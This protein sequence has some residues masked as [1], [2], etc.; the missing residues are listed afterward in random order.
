MQRKN[1]M[2]YIKKFSPL[3]QICAFSVGLN[4]VPQSLSAPQW[5]GPIDED[6]KAYIDFN[7]LKADGAI[8]WVT[9]S[10][11]Q[12]DGSRM[13]I[14][15]GIDCKKWMYSFRSSSGSNGRW[16]L[17]GVGTAAERTASIV[18]R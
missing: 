2:H 13:T 1:K 18:C 4:I 14:T 6:K 11:I 7:S 9:L 16:N 12:D 8:R 17:I 15:S 10:I 5:I 3:A